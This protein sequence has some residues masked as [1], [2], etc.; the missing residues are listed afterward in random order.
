VIVEHF[1]QQFIN[2]TA[3][4]SS[5]GSG[6][7]PTGEASWRSWCHPIVMVLTS[8]DVDRI[9][10]KNNVTFTEMIKP[11]GTS[12]DTSSVVFRSPTKAISLRNFGVRFM[13]AAEFEPLEQKT[14]DRVIH[15]HVAVLLLSL[16]I[17]C[18]VVGVIVFGACIKA[19]IAR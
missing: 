19:C 4:S 13:A 16:Q 10:H 5:S 15:L 18:C 14:A 6:N 3:S 2:M 11:W 9:C 8:T 7:I 12:V 1:L 17:F